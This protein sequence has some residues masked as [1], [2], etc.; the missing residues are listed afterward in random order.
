M[1]NQINSTNNNYN[2]I[3]K[4]SI[5]IYIYIYFFVWMGLCECVYACDYLNILNWVKVDNT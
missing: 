4:Y 3:W 1:F 5:H 2:E